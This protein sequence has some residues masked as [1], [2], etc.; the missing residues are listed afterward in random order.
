MAEAHGIEADVNQAVSIGS[1]WREAGIHNDVVEGAV[2]L[3]DE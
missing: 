1:D 3:R 2:G